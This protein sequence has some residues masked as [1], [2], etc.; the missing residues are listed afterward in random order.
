MAS[1]GRC[2][3]HPLTWS[4]HVP[5]KYLPAALSAT[6]EVQEFPLL[7]SKLMARVMRFGD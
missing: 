5:G 7:D 1:E 6:D 2:A 3:H 4:S